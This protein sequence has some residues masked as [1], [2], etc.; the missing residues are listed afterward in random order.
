MVVSNI[1]IFTP[2]WGDD[3]VWLIF[4]KWVETT[5]QFVIVF[6]KG[7]ECKTMVVKWGFWPLTICWCK[8][9]TEHSWAKMKHFSLLNGEQLAGGSALFSIDP[10]R[11]RSPRDPKARASEEGDLPWVCSNFISA[12]LSANQEKL[13]GGNSHIFCFHPIIW[14]NDAFWL[15]FFHWVVHQLEK[16]S[17]FK[18]CCE[19]L[20]AVFVENECPYV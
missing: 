5:N 14:G 12:N 1:F 4:F 13:G 9:V 7:F 11:P 18:I 8:I 19:L 15:I 16:H 10:G 2:T 3:L 17:C 20:G 6:G